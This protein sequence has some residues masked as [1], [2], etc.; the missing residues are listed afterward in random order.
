MRKKELQQQY[1]QLRAAGR[2]VIRTSGRARTELSEPVRGDGGVE[3]ASVIL[4]YTS[5]L[6]LLEDLVS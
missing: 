1:D 6:D 3:V 4:D 5:A 2:A